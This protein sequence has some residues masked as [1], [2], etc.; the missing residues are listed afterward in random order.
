M[1]LKSP[2]AFPCQANRHLP[3]HVLP[4]HFT[5]DSPWEATQV[6]SWK[7]SQAWRNSI[8][9]VHCLSQAELAAYPLQQWQAT[10]KMNEHDT[11]SIV[12]GDLM[13]TSCRVEWRRHIKHHSRLISIGD[14]T[15]SS[16]QLPQDLHCHESWSWPERSDNLPTKWSDLDWLHKTE[17]WVYQ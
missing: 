5:W 1:L 16:A 6:A 17:G 7:L 2:G 13:S 14:S 11:L 10:G 12:I 4:S 9:L 8:A 3:D 15:P